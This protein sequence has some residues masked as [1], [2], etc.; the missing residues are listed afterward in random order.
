M[1]LAHAQGVPI[2]LHTPSLTSLHQD[3]SPAFIFSLQTLSDMGVGPLFKEYLLFDV[4]DVQYIAW[5]D[6]RVDT[7]IA[8]RVLLQE[9]RTCT[10][11]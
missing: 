1:D 4:E 7:L 10:L 11:T 5:P 2:L 8:V 6:V 9:H 3:F